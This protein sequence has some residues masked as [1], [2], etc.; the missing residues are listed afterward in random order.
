MT[1]F[2]FFCML[3][4]RF[5]FVCLFGSTL[6]Y[7]SLDRRRA[8]SR[9][10]DHLDSLPPPSPT[11]N[12]NNFGC[13][14]SPLIATPNGGTPI[15]P[16]GVAP[17]G[18]YF[19]YDPSWNHPENLHHH[20]MMATQSHHLSPHPHHH[21]PHHHM[22][23]PVPQPMDV[24]DS[25]SPKLMMDPRPAPLGNQE[26][27]PPQP[28][29]LPL[30]ASNPRPKRDLR[31]T[32]SVNAADHMRPVRLP[33]TE[34]PP[35]RPTRSSS[36]LPPLKPTNGSRYLDN[37]RHNESN[38]NFSTEMLRLESPVAPTAPT[39]RLSEIKHSTPLMS[40]ADGAR[41]HK[42]RNS[43]HDVSS[44]SL[45]S[46]SGSSSFVSPE[47]DS[48][49]ATLTVITT[50]S[51]QP[52]REISKPFEMS[53]FYKYSTKFRR[54]S[55]QSEEPSFSASVPDTTT[56]PTSPQPQTPSSSGGVPQQKGVY[57]PLTPLSCKAIDEE[58]PSW[59]H[60]P[61][62]QAVPVNVTNKRAATLV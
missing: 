15:S 46:S 47:S 37:S 51:Y 36:E 33:V 40:L 11:N 32:A 61:L 3:I 62:H 55:T 4:F 31:P 38:N 10:M 42:E 20:V 45:G 50:G 53:D 43:V 24:V 18:P 21:L 58:Q 39:T 9:S 2:Y 56:S 1:F 14:P 5:V 49:N 54:S 48:L 52:S 34:L 59:D 22:G 26:N 25:A 8:S 16:L 28:E 17:T 41:L 6:R 12:N 57:Q 27:I 44:S 7:G 60:S 13:V 19:H 29:L 23:Y 30:R 35:L